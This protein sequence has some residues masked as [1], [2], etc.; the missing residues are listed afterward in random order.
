MRDLRCHQDVAARHVAYLIAVY[1]RRR[2]V[3]QA[4]GG[5]THSEGLRAAQCSAISQRE[6]LGSECRASYCSLGKPA[7]CL[8]RLRVEVCTDQGQL[9]GRLLRPRICIESS[10]A[11]QAVE[12]VLSICASHIAPNMIAWYALTVKGCRGSAWRGPS[13]RR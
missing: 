9:L 8:H 2:F 4:V 12:S 11:C 13:E 6:H 3:H 10:T 7:S 1:Y 5:C